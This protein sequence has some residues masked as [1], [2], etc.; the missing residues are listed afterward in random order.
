MRV[1]PG[2]ALNFPGIRALQK[3]PK[4]RKLPKAPAI[5]MLKTIMD[6]LLNQWNT[7]LDKS[8]PWLVFLL[9]LSIWFIPAASIHSIDPAAVAP[10]QSQWLMIVLSLI[11]FLMIMALC[12]WLLDRQ[13]RLIGLPP[14]SQIVL[15]F[16]LI[17]QCQQL[18]F[19]FFSFA[20]VLL[21]ALACLVAIC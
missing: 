15:H 7:L 14:I 4:I 16:K 12:W 8:K 3:I 19:Y 2:P 20:L 13:W 18:A 17:T 1:L 21:A 10:D 6:G 5:T 11:T 9:L